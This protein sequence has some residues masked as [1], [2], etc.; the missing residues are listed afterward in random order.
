M[1]NIFEIAL[2]YRVTLVIVMKFMHLHH[3]YVLE[4]SEYVYV[5]AVKQRHMKQF[6]SLGVDMR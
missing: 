6:V 1:L 5:S 4:R 3:T 2:S